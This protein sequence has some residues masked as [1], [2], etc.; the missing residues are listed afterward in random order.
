MSFT[1]GKSVQFK[2]W[3][4][5]NGME[6]NWSFV[7]AIDNSDPGIYNDTFE[8][9]IWGPEA[10]P[11]GDPTDRAKGIL[12]GGNIIVHTKVVLRKSF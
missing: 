1:G 9:K 11:E 5:I 3:A 4:S 8:I 12:R 7:K 6:D 2:S 10:D